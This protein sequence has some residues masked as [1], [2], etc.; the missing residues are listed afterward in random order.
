ML[1][2]AS[3]VGVLSQVIVPLPFT[4]VPISLGTFGVLLVGGARSTGLT[5]QRCAL[6]GAA[7]AALR[8]ARYLRPHPSPR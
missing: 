2:G 8:S 6:W 4:P 7:T 3:V 5:H 1:G